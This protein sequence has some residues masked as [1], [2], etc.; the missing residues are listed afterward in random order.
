MV[1]D[2]SPIVGKLGTIYIYINT[3]MIT[4]TGHTDVRILHKNL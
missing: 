1:V 4:Y 3:P 2:Y